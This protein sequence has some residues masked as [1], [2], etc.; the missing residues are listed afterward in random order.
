M[1]PYVR[2]FYFF[3]AAAVI[4]A[5]VP[6]LP[7]AQPALYTGNI[8]VADVQAPAAIQANAPTPLT[9]E[10]LLSSL[11]RDLLAHFSVDGELQLELMRPWTPPSR[12]ASDWQVEILEFPAMPATSMLVRCRVLADGEQ[13]DQTTF[14]LRASLW[15]D[16]WVTRQPLTAGTIFDATLLESR[17]TDVLRERDVLPS[18]VGGRTYVFARA[19]PAGRMLTWRDIGRRPLVK[20]GEVVEVVASEGPLIITL[21]GVAME[22]GADGDTVM[23]RNPESRKDFPARVVEEKRVEV[24]F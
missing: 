12:V 24:R 11:S 21:K 20:K 6:L 13:L 9:R 22:N 1:K 14:V 4:L 3:A 23:V 2:T 16:A 7:G 15:R 19:V 10:L 18:A 5:A 8:S 17:R